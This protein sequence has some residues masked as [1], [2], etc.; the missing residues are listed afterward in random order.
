MATHSAGSTT[1]AAAG[2]ARTAGSVGS[3]PAAASWAAAAADPTG[4]AVTAG[5]R[6]NC[7]AR[8]TRRHGE[9]LCCC[10]RAAAIAVAAAPAMTSGAMNFSIAL[11]FPV[12]HQ[13]RKLKKTK[14]ERN[15]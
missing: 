12:Y 4:A 7:D 6:G 3:A 8:H 2:A 13:D 14:Y 10:N 9:G 1:A 11:M 5:A 15:L